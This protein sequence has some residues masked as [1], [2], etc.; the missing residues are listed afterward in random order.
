L[1]V[2]A[3][4]PGRSESSRKHREK[5]AYSRYMLISTRIGQ[6]R[7]HGSKSFQYGLVVPP[8]LSSGFV[9]LLNGPNISLLLFFYFTGMTCRPN[10]IMVVDGR[11]LLQKVPQS[12][13]G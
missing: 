6:V 8:L 11:C 12:P 3:F 1:L 5:L 4:P 13:L 2:K 9:Y 10:N 7:R